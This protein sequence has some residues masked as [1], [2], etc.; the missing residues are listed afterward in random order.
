MIQIKYFSDEKLVTNYESLKDFYFLNESFKNENLLPFFNNH[1]YRSNLSITK[2]QI[3]ILNAMLKW[4][5]LD[6]FGANLV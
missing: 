1:E 3:P 5:I 4:S 2:N 6:N